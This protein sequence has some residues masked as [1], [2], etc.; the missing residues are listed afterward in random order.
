MRHSL[1]VNLNL[2]LATLGA[3]IMTLGM[4]KRKA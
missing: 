2:L 4:L 1:M 3:V